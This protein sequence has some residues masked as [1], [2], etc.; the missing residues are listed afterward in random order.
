MRAVQSPSAVN[1][2][3]RIPAQ[4][5][6]PMR[7]IA[8]RSATMFVVLA[9]STPAWAQSVSVLL[10]KG[11]FAEETVGDL[12]A[13]IKVYAQIVAEADAS[14]AQVAQ[15]HYRLGICYQKKG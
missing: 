2:P 15:A 1:E 10:Q 9:L 4:K 6:T 7:Q 12:D 8:S 5:E 13:A 11:I 14:Q 3:V